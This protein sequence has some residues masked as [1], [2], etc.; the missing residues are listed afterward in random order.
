[1]LEFHSIHQTFP[2]Q[3]FVL[4]VEFFDYG[5]MYVG[6]LILK[7][8]GHKASIEEKETIVIQL[9]GYHDHN[10]QYKAI[11]D[12]KVAKTLKSLG[13]SKEVDYV[14]QHDK[15]SKKLVLYVM[16]ATHAEE[17][18]QLIKK[19]AEIL[20]GFFDDDD[21]EIIN[22]IIDD[23]LKEVRQERETKKKPQSTKESTKFGNKHTEISLEVN[24]KALRLS[25]KLT[26]S[27]S[28]SNANDNNGNG[29]GGEYGTR[30]D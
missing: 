25:F 7:C 22:S 5:C 19:L 26:I 10:A 12:P 1:M 6:F 30:N 27:Q 11:N 28:S 23:K 16:M 2:F 21:K 15:R 3:I 20:P 24:F 18:K 8:Q 13:I 9:E 17:A 14:Y 29:N 4:V